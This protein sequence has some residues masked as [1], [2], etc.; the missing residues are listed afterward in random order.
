MRS[1]SKLSAVLRTL[2]GLGTLFFLA[3]IYWSSHLLEEQLQQVR[4]ELK[5]VREE[6]KA[7]SLAL[8]PEILAALGSNERVREQGAARPHIDPAYPNLLVRDPY[9]DE[10]LPKT[11]GK[12]FRPSGILRECT[13]GRPHTLH[14]FA[15]WKSSNDLTD[16][17]I[18]RVAR[19]CFGRYERYSP[20]LAIKVERRQCDAGEEFWVHLREGISWEPLKQEHLPQGITL[21]PHFLKRHPVTAR[22]FKFFYDVVMNPNISSGH[23]ITYRAFF[24]DI[25]EFRLV[26]D[27]TFVVTWAKRPAALLSGEVIERVKYSALLH[28]IGLSPLPCW[29]LQYFPDGSKIC[30]ADDEETYRIDTIFA[31]NFATHWSQNVIASCG[32]WLFDGMSDH[33]IRFRRNPRYWD[34][35]AALTEAVSVQ[36]LDSAEVMWQEFKAGKVDLFDTF[37]APEKL[38]E[39]RDFVTS[40]IY[41]SQAGAGAGIERVDYLQRSYRYV[42]WN[43]ARPLFAS[44][45]VRRALTMAIDRQRIIAQN[46]NGMAIELTGPFFPK[47]SG[48][49]AHVLS[50]PY[51][52]LE[53]KRLLEEEGW[54]DTNG[55]G[56]LDKE[57]DGKR[58]RF[59]FTLFHYAGSAQGR[60]VTDAIATGL[61]EIGI[62]C[63]PLGL[64]VADLAGAVEGRDFDAI[65]MAWVLG[66]PPEDPRQLWHSS[67]A[68]QKGSSNF[69]AF[70]NPEVD[71]LIELLDYEDDADQRTQLYHKLHQII[72]EE[73]PYTFLFVPRIAFL[74]RGYVKNAF[75]PLERRDLI[76]DAEV[77]EPSK[78]LLWLDGGGYQLR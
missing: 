37:Y 36:F 67:G 61:K 10:V 3:M 39:L 71:R 26:D 66:T 29:L 57:I 24:Q 30:E 77:E 19:L 74:Y 51:D 1:G 34:P 13:L 28:T 17:C 7:G 53:A 41:A 43:A 49:D 8:S 48:Y 59:S 47:S 63:K 20:D 55:D 72:H 31:Q 46:A 54:F 15:E 33:E 27:L 11:L 45:K 25:L 38:E 32:P 16:R 78:S 68:S 21:A 23:A 35:S 4:G 60:A 40:P 62:E 65:Y 9:F 70:N 58:V 50:W 12:G 76:P 75:S 56:I 44:S 73:A 42:G 2:V 22:D 52:P 64:D 6:F 18:G 5:E 14:R 69:V